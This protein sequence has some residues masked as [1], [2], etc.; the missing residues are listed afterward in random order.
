MEDVGYLLERSVLYATELGLGTCW[1]GGTFTYSSF[2]QRIEAQEG[3]QIPAVI[4][5]GYAAQRPRIVDGIIRRAVGAHRRQPWQELFFE[6]DLTKPL[7]PESAGDYAAP[8]EMVRI[9][10]SASNRQPWRVLQ[11]GNQWHFYRR[12]SPAG[13]GW[14][15]GQSRPND[16]LQRMDLGIAMCHFEMTARDLDLGGHWAFEEPPV[17]GIQELAYTATWVAS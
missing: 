17:E 10:P 12:R 9:A 5:I 16:S 2:A 8:L 11:D 7:T 15:T 1:L 3:E 13:R 4:S 14:S 6:G